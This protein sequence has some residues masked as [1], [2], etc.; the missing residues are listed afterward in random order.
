MRGVRRFLGG[1]EKPSSLVVVGNIDVLLAKVLT[2]TIRAE[3]ASC[4]E[5]AYP[6]VPIANAKHLLFLESEGAVVAFA[7]ERGWIVRD[8]RLYFPAV[9]SSGGDEGDDG[10][11]GNAD[12]A[13]SGKH[14]AP[15]PDALVA[16][17]Q[18]IE[19]AIGYARELETIV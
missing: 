14:G 3:I 4:S 18:V 10:F 2:R 12:S 6:S 16:S 13:L 5:R 17:G 1:T 8:G 19:N 11:G 9:S 7:R 15:G